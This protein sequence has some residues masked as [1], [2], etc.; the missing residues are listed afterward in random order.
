MPP[1]FRHPA[2]TLRNEVDMWATAGFSANP[3]GPPVRA[4]RMLPG[5]I[6]RLKAGMDL[7][8]FAKIDALVSNLKNEYPKEYPAEVVGQFWLLPAITNWLEMR[9][10]LFVVRE[11][12]ASFS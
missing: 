7:A 10:I 5:A 6:G 2:K 11:L 1:G 9:T 3:F 12:L 4:I 8:C